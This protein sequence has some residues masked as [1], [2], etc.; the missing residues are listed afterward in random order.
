MAENAK[1]RRSG[2]LTW[3]WMILALVVVGGFLAWIGMAS[4]PSSVAVVEEEGEEAVEGA[5]GEGATFVEV[6][7]D[8]LAA[9]KAAYE[10]QRVRVAG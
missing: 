1:G 7:K 3:L 4:E 5:A 2:S 10:G 6:P 9:D 8:T